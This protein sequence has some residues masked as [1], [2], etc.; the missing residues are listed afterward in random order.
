MKYTAYHVQSQNRVNLIRYAD[1]FIVTAATR[2]I[3][4][5]AKEVIR[6]FL[7]VRGLELSEE[8]TVISRIEDGFDMLGWTFRKF[9]GKLITKPSKKAIKAFSAIL[10]ETI[11]R[12]GKAWPQ[13]LLISKLN[14]QIRGWTNYHQS[15]CAKD[16]FSHMDY[17]LFQL[18]WRWA[19]RRHPKKNRGW[20]SQ[21]YWHSKDGRNW[22]FST[23]DNQ[24]LSLA[25]TP[26]IRHTKVRMEA[27]PY[28]DTQYF[29]DRRFQ[30][31]MERLS[32]RFKQVW[33]NQ[34][35]CCYHCGPPMDTSNEREIF[36]KIPKSMGGRDEVRNMAYVHK[37]C[38]SI[39]LE[40]RAKA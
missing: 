36:L 38:Q 23:E 29:T 6:D 14:Q 3:A 25:Y 2:E 30:H 7:R 4:E 32:G 17:I 1:D 16:T 20:I 26:I 31:G 8:K 21:N 34:K 33:K 40:R 24:L 13:D 19:K 5:S 27:N 10:S 28:F 12:R 9:K 37:H 35:G 22:V 18:L 15:V 11:L 39:F